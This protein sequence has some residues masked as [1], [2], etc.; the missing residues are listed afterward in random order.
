MKFAH[1]LVLMVTVVLAV[2]F[3]AISYL[4]ISRNFQVMQA[5]AITENSRQHLLERYSLETELRKLRDSYV[6]SLEISLQE[7]IK[8]MSAYLGEDNLWQAL[9]DNGGDLLYSTLPPQVQDGVSAQSIDWAQPGYILQQLGDQHLIVFASKISN[10]DAPFYLLSAYDISNVYAER[11]RQTGSM[12]GMNAIVLLVAIAVVSAASF[13][14]TRPISKLSRT[15]DQIAQGAYSA[16]SQV[17]TDDEIGELSHNFNQ[18]AAAVEQRVE[19]LNLSIQQREDFVSAFTHEIKTPMTAIIGYSD[20]LRFQQTDPELYQRS[21]QFIYR[22]AVRLENLS[23]KLLMLMGLSDEG[24]VP[25][26]LLVKDMLRDVLRSVFSDLQEHK[27][28]IQMRPAE[29]IVLLGDKDLLVDLLRNLLLNAIKAEP[30]NNI[31]QIAWQVEGERCEITVSDTG[32]GIPKDELARIV[33]PFYMVDKSRARKQ[34]GSGV[35]L[36]LCKKIAELHGS[37][38]TFHSTVG[39]GTQVSFFVPLYTAPSAA[40]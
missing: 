5:S 14:L 28:Q 2:S 35:G 22:E 16:R 40:E 6:Y 1:K 18:M 23:Q 19:Q 4:T 12:L 39:K 37:E 25:G 30:Q 9:Y 26:P 33:E 8:T 17:L 15:S 10:G 20:L 29:H 24:F 34:G 7:Q 32:K 38:L 13:R 11:N 3:S 21:T 31:I 27:I 36:T